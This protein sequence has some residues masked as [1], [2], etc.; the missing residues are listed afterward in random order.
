MTLDSG[1]T[2]YLASVCAPLLSSII[3]QM[4]PVCI[5]LP[6]ITKASMIVQAL[7]GGMYTCPGQGDGT[8]CLLP[9]L[10]TSGSQNCKHC[11]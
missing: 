5:S 8:V 6:Y 2:V 10:G 4:K 1:L 3:L 7:Q 11:G 9:A